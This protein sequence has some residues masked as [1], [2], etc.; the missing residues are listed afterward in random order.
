ARFGI[1]LPV[2]AL[3]QGPT[4]AKLADRVIRQL[5]GQDET[6]SSAGGP[7]IAEQAQMIAKQQGVD[8]SAEMIADVTAAV[9]AEMVAVKK[10]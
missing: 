9:Q 6:S 5:R 8:A 1:R 7:T 10:D 2:M 3:S 4:I